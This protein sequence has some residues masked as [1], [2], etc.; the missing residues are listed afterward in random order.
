M[1]EIS[2]IDIN[3]W[4]KKLDENGFL[5]LEGIL[6]E[7]ELEIYQQF[8]TDVMEGNACFLFYLYS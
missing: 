6:N 8:Y 1:G 4:T 7:N 2:E 5:A 3:E